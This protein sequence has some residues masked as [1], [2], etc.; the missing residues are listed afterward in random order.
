MTVK[1]YT[2]VR[3]N[4]RDMINKV[5]DDSDTITI[6][7]KDRN[8]VLMSEDDY[9][10]IMETLYLQQ[11]PSNAKHLAESIENLERGNVKS[12]EIEI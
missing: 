11:N 2:F 9:D 8:A 4:F 6:T 7:T 3:D 5:N 10:A 12:K 1:N